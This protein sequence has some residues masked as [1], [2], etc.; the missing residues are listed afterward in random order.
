MT[1]WG[2]LWATVLIFIGWDEVLWPFSQGLASNCDPLDFCP[3]S[4]KD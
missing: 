4:S 3:L 1:V 2:Q